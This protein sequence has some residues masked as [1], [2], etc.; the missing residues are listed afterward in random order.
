MEASFLFSFSYL[1]SLRIGDVER[2]QREFWIANS[3]S[4]RRR[5]CKRIVRSYH[6]TSRGRGDGM[7]ALHELLMRLMYELLNGF[8][9]F[10]DLYYGTWDI[11]THRDREHNQWVAKLLGKVYRN[12]ATLDVLRNVKWLR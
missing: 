11:S 5:L 9:S 12:R 6:K 10:N 7:E 3:R 1:C 2:I 8:I 4:S